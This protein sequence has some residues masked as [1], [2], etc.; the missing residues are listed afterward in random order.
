MQNSYPM[1]E[2]HVR[3]LEKIVL[4]F[5][6]GLAENATSWEKRNNKR[7]GRIGNVCRQI[8][9]DIKQGATYE[10]VTLLLQ[11]IRNDSSFSSLRDNRGSLERLGELEKYFEQRPVE[12]KSWYY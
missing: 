9:Y 4:K 3:H 5:V 12:A 7:Y 6:T 2:W 11:K 1:I 8:N 10:Q